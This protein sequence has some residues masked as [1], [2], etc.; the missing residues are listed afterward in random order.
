MPLWLNLTLGILALLIALI[1]II[2]WLLSGRI[3]RRMR[4]D[5]P[6]TPEDLGLPFEHV[7][8][9]ARDG[10]K[11]GGRLTGEEGRRPVVIFCAGM[12]GS[13]DGDTYMLTPFYKAGLDVLQFDWRGH[14]IS[15]GPRV[16]LGVK[17]ALDLQGAI[18]FLQSRGV[19]HIGLMGF[20]MGGGVALRVAAQDRRVACL[21]VDG[22]FADIASTLEGAIRPRLGPL[23]RPL[24]WLVLRM[25]ELR[26]G[27]RTSEAS[28]LPHVHAIG[29]RPVFFIHGAQDPLIPRPDQDALFNACSDPKSLWRVEGAAHREAHERQPEAYTQKVIDFFRANLR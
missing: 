24:V 17:E 23:A 14:G 1:L 12:F 9:A 5:P 15:D 22:P 7:T 19:K 21:A 8:F 20:S 27:L 10:V 25:A 13:M 4:P 6:S 16:T 18:D 28:P 29:P 11:L 2:A 26:L 3:A